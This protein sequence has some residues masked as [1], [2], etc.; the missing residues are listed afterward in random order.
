VVVRVKIRLK[1]PAGQIETTALVNSGFETKEPEIILPSEV[2]ELLGIED[3]EGAEYEVAGG[4]EV[5][6]AK[7]KGTIKV[8]LLSNN[9]LLVSFDGARP[10]VLAG[11]EEV[12]ISGYLASEL[13]ISLIDIKEGLWCLREEVGKVV[14]R[15]EEKQVWKKD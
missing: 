9:E 12:I 11:E 13:R 8:E 3:F 6:A 4:A 2:S 5:I 14:R 15:S 1:G 10:V 7:A